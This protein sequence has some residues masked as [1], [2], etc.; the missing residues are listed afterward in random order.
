MI[1]PEGG[2]ASRDAAGG[3]RMAVVATR[4]WKCADGAA[5]AEQRR[6]AMFIHHRFFNYDD[7]Q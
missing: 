1:I 5:T 7:E 3:Y 6:P 2:L 4:R